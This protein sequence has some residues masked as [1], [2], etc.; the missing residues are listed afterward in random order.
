MQRLCE[1]WVMGVSG[2][3]NMDCGYWVRRNQNVKQRIHV[4]WV[5][6]ALVLWI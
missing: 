2:F 5:S 1:N 3:E 4:K 6:I